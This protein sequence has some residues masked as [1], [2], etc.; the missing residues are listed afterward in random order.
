LELVQATPEPTWR[1][2]LL[3]DYAPVTTLIRNTVAFTAI[4]LA[5]L[6][7]LFLYLRQRRRAIH[8]SLAAKAALQRA[9][10][11]LERKVAARTAAL[12]AT[13]EQ[14]GREIAERQRTEVVLRE[15]QDGLVQA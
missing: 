9:H 8:A 5:F 11:D 4:A 15:A 13:N 2:I 14:L 7:V 3:S 1:L 10:D 12:V 6:F